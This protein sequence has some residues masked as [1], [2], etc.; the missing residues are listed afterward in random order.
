LIRSIARTRGAQSGVRY[1][2][3]FSNIRRFINWER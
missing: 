1:A 2:E 3:A